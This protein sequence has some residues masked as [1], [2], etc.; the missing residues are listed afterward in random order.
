MFCFF[1]P[2]PCSYFLILWWSPNVLKCVEFFSSG[3]LQMVKKAPIKILTYDSC[4]FLS[5]QSLPS[6]LEGDI[7]TRDRWRS[8]QGSNTHGCGAL[9]LLYV[10]LR[11]IIVAISNTL[12]PVAFTPFDF[13]VDRVHIFVLL[14]PEN[15]NL[16]FSLEKKNPGFG[17][18]KILHILMTIRLR[19]CSFARVKLP[20]FILMNR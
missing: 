11:D 14:K 16:D 5:V 13:C 2:V 12:L 1:L 18:F 19:P 7:S 17:G 6:P 3:N 10:I 9:S 8:P 4:W 15:D 20:V